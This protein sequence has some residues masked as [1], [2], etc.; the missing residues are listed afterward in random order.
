MAG[1][2]YISKLTISGKAVDVNEAFDG[3]RIVLNNKRKFEINIVFDEAYLRSEVTA[4]MIRDALDRVEK[5]KDHTRN[6]EEII[7]YLGDGFRLTGKFTN[8]NGVPVFTADN[9]SKKPSDYGFNKIDYDFNK[10][11]LLIHSN[12]YIVAD[13]EFTKIK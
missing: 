10:D 6:V 12:K 1:S 2:F 9:T 13:F 3:A 7:A 8:N 5:G 4:D 11:V